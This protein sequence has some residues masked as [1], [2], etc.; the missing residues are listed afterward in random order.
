MRRWESPGIC[1][2]NIARTTEVIRIDKMMIIK[3]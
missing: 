2:G 3:S 1:V